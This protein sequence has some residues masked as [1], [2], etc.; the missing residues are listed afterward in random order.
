[1]NRCSIN[2]Q[3][4]SL[5][6]TVILISVVTV[7]LGSSGVILKRVYHSYEI[8]LRQWSIQRSLQQLGQCWQ[9]DIHNS[10]S[11]VVLS[12][13]VIEIQGK[14]R[15]IYRLDDSRNIVR[16]NWIKDKLVGIDRFPLDAPVDIQFTRDDSGRIPVLGMRVHLQ[17][18]SP[19]KALTTYYA[20]LGVERLFPDQDLMPED[21]N[22]K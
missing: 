4:Y 13:N 6:E 11:G 9:E 10:S 17:S 1:M 12:D 16:Q 21:N 20:R 2:R 8:S 15:L 19:P 5:V 3:G 7:I 14:N 22:A 18:A